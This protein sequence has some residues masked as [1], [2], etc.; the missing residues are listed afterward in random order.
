MAGNGIKPERFLRVH[1]GPRRTAGSVL[2]TIAMA[3]WVMEAEGLDAPTAVAAVYSPAQARRGRSGPRTSDSFRRNWSGEFTAHLDTLERWFARHPGILEVVCCPVFE[4]VDGQRHTARP[5]HEVV[6]QPDLFHL[7]SVD[8][9]GFGFYERPLARLAATGT[10]DAVAQLWGQAFVALEKAQEESR[11]APSSA[12]VRRDYLNEALEHSR[13]LVAALALLA[14]RPTGRTTAHW[15]LA[16]MRKQLLDH[17][18]AGGWFLAMD[19]LDFPALVAQ[20]AQ[21]R[22]GTVADDEVV[23]NLPPRPDGTARCTVLSRRD[24]VAPAETLAFVESAGPELRRRRPAPGWRRGCS[25]LD[26]PEGARMAA[27]RGRE[28]PYALHPKAL[29]LLQKRL[30]SYARAVEG[31]PRGVRE[32]SCVLAPHL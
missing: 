27:S 23:I 24:L 16:F 31:K 8:P 13:M 9:L 6:P 7:A 30:G 17:L 21:L 28:G 29:A 19:A 20:A 5:I 14:T 18:S 22:R 1:S 12:S 10:W 32:S 26:V 25:P 2:R 11:V 4:V 3:G 15:V